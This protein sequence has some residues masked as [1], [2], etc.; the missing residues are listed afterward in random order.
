MH[1]DKRLIK[2]A[3][4]GDMRAY[5]ELFQKYEE[6]IYKLA[7]V[8]AKNREDVL[9]IVQEVAYRSCKH[10]SSLK[11]PAYFKTWLIRILMNCASDYL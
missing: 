11:E 1:V 6:E 7:F 3:Q 9:D 4:K 8:Y 2:C 10:I 5:E